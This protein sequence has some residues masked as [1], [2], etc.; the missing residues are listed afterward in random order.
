LT[1]PDT[2]GYTPKDSVPTDFEAARRLLAE[3]GYPGGKGLPAFELLFNNSESHRLIAEAIQEM[4]R[5]ELGVDVHLVNQ[6]RKSTLEARRAGSFQ[7]MRDVWI[8]DFVDPASFLDIFRSDSGNNYTGWKNPDYY[9]LL[10]AAARENNP[11]ARIQFFQ[12]AEA[13]LLNAA[14]L[15]PIYYY[16]HVFLIQPSV[17]GWNPTLLDH[18]P[19]KHVWLEP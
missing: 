7:I 15:I 1:P 10:F 16:T 9:A 19:Y 13:I 18:H 8:A 14:P 4:W 6:D 12:K 11:T 5:R 17:K 2:A 3:A